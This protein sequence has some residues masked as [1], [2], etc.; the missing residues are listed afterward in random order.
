MRKLTFLLFIL[1]SNFLIAQ[2]DKGY[3]IELKYMGY[4]QISQLD[5]EANYNIFKYIGIGL[6]VGLQS[7]I[8]HSIYGGNLPDN[9]NT[10][11]EIS[12]NSEHVSNLILRPSV[13]FRTPSIKFLRNTISLFITPGLII[14]PFN[15]DKINIEYTSVTGNNQLQTLTKSYNTNFFPMRFYR[16]VQCGFEYRFEDLCIVGGYE[17]SNQDIYSRRR[18]MVFENIKLNDYLSVHRSLTNHRRDTV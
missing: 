2:T 6:G 14:Y 13:R 5:L 1:I 10:A 4:R 7:D 17:L 3:D 12:E 15:G 18:N 8:H 11:W 9:K 16:S